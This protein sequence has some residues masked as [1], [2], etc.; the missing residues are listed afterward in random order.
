M[1]SIDDFEKF[2]HHVIHEEIV[3]DRYATYVYYLLNKEIFPKEATQQL[4]MEINKRRYQSTIKDLFGIV[5]NNEEDYVKLL[6]S[7]VE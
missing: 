3:A 7:F 4:D 1:F 5:K 6:E 2:C